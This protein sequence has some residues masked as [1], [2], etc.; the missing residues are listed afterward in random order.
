MKNDGGE[1]NPARQ[2][3]RRGEIWTELSGYD[4][5]PLI[6]EVSGGKFKSKYI[7]WSSAV[8]AVRSIYPDM[9]WEFAHERYF[10]DRTAEV[11]C[12]VVILRVSRT[13]WLPV[14]NSSNKPIIEPDARQISDARMRCLVKTLAS[15]FGFG[16]ELWSGDGL[17]KAKAPVT[18]LPMVEVLSK[19]ENLLNLAELKISLGSYVQAAESRARLSNIAPEEEFALHAAG[20]RDIPIDQLEWMPPL[21]SAYEAWTAFSND[22]RRALWV[23]PSKGGVLTT[24]ERKLLKSNTFAAAG[25]YYHG[26]ITAHGS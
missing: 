10:A 3:A 8:A 9:E 21:M 18:N 11:S 22:E 2:A 16:L 5:K 15:G 26:D 24:S 20:N 23:A 14:M 7:P 12:T 4:V 6:K 13:M 1:T 19:P 17:P 25:R